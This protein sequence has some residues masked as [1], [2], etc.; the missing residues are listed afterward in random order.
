MANST[1]STLESLDS[2]LASMLAD[3]SFSTTALAVT[4][5]ALL[6]YPLFTSSDPDTH[7]LLLARQAQASP[8]R[9]RGQ[10]AFY[11][12]PES[13]HGYPL[14]SGLN[15]KDAGAPR[16][17][18]GKDGDL[19]D[20][21]RE[22][23]RGGSVGADGKT[24]PAGLIMSV[25]GKAEVVEHQAEEISKEINIVGQKF[26]N[27]G[28]KKLAIYL[29]NSIE[30]LIAVFACTFYGITPVLLPFNLPHSKVYELL[31]STEVD[32]LVAAAGT[33]PM[34][35]LTT[36]VSTLRLLTWVVEP[37]SRHIDWNELPAKASDRV[38]VNV[39]HDVIE[40]EKASANSSLPPNTPD[41]T[42]P[43]VIT[44]WQ[45][46]DIQSKPTITSFTQAN[47]V[48]ATAS[49]ITAIPLRQRLTP[50]DL[51]LPADHFSHSY[52]LCNTFAALFAHASIAINSVAAPG[53]DL[54]LAS[55]SVSPTVIIASA[56]SLATQYARETAGVTSALQKFGK[57]TQD[58]TVSAGRMPTDGLL[59]R[60]LAPSNNEPGK[61]RLI[62][63]SDRLRDSP[64]LTSAMLSDLRIF[65]RS[66]I[67]YALTAPGVA[68]AVAQTNVFDYRSSAGSA[69]NHFGVPLACVEIR[70]ESGNDADLEGT[71]PKGEIVVSGRSVV[72]GET[73]LGVKGRIREDCTLAYA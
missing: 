16:W 51:V 6:L 2:A 35:E 72:G 20:V 73:R 23:V 19:R 9:K 22:V 40:A 44:I 25:F 47:I 26:K 61:L 53:V 59:F 48:A 71:E 65:T 11:R 37:A 21:W 52:V 49:L 10:S 30:Y 13:P 54:S 50:S 34:D 24:I 28:V 70:L 7:P 55:R 4:I 68:G 32:G 66:R 36:Q 63:T 12:S 67:V 3:W 31:N 64:V 15:V 69:H 29:P 17:A 41:E 38:T 46:A 27:A 8:V 1:H 5:I 14:K 33:L 42:V 45:P 57:Y 62:L 58:Q 18:S 43:N 60:L 56:E 39:W